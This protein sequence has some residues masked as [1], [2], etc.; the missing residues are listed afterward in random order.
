V[1]LG[2]EVFIPPLKWLS[3]LVV[4]DDVELTTPVTGNM[5]SFYES[6]PLDNQGISC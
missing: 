4:L 3:E 5:I 1:R 6:S 2:A